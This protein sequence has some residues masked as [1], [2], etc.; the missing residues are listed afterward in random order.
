M[1]TGRR[2]VAEQIEE[3][4]AGRLFLDTHA[5]RP[6][7]EEQTGVEVVGEVHQQL[8]ATLVD[9]DELALCRL[10]L[11]LLGAALALAA[12]DHHTALVDVQRLRDGCQGIEHA[13][14]SLFR[15]D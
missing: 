12:L 8:H 7:V 15:I 2:G 3:A 14:R 4:L 1:H 11:V 6:V 5:H 10:A 13:G 9:L